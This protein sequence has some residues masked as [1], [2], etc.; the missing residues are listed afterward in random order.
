MFTELDQ[1][2]DSHEACDNPFFASARRREWTRPQ[3]GAFA[4]DY[5][6]L[7]RS[8]PKVLAELVPRVRDDESRMFLSDILLSELGAGKPDKIHSRLLLRVFDRLGL[9][10]AAK[11]PA[12]FPETLRLVEGMRVLYRDEDLPVSLGAQYGLERMANPMISNL[13]EGFKS[14][15]ELTADDNEYFE[16]H[17]VEEPRHFAL[18]QQCVTEH[19]PEGGSPGQLREGVVRCLDLFAD[20]WRRLHRELEAGGPRR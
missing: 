8:F 10:A 15:P 14:F 13:Y 6:H 2:I 18:M 19:L 7:I 4:S 3:V 20:F 11:K 17:L 16:V 1:F 5:L 12:R 9:S